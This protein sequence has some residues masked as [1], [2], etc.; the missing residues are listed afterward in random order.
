MQQPEGFEIPEEGKI[1]QE[2]LRVEAGITRVEREA[3]EE[4]ETL[5]L[6]PSDTEPNVFVSSN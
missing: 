1:L 4:L 6:Y 2:P 5:A 3:E